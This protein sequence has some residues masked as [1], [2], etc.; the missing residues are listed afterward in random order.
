MDPELIYFDPNQ[1][2]SDMCKAFKNFCTR[3]NLRYNAQF[4][5]PPRT[6]MDSAIQRW[7]LEHPPTSTNPN[8]KPT[9]I[10]FDTMKEDWKSKD[11]VVKVLGMFS[12]ARLNSD[13]EIS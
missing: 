3:F 13:W 5:E 11:K 8:P 1:H 9:V 4:G 12:S 6:T 2:P 10:Q 7:E